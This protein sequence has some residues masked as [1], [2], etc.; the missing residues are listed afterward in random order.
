MSILETLSALM[1]GLPSARMG[2][3]LGLPLEKVESGIKQSLAVLLSAI[4]AKQDIA[5]ALEKLVQTAVELERSGGLKALVDG[6]PLA[7]GQD[8][9]PLI[10][11]VGEM[12]TELLNG[13]AEDVI[14]ALASTLSMPLD[15]AKRLLNQ[16]SL[17]LAGF[18]GEQLKRPGMNGPALAATLATER[19]GYAVWLPPSLASWYADK[20]AGPV[21]TKKCSRRWL[22]WVL[23]ALLVILA[24]LFGLKGCGDEKSADNP[25]ISSTSGPAAS[26]AVDSVKAA[27]GEFFKLLLPD[28]TEL[29]VPELGIENRL[30]KFIKDDAQQ[31]DPSIW[32]SF[33]RLTFE[34]NSNTLMPGSEEQLKNI[35]AIMKAFPKVHLKLGGYTDNTGTPEGNLTLSDARARSVM[36]EL[37]KLGVQADRLEAKGYG[38]EHPVASNDT[39]EGRAKNRRIDVNV[40]AK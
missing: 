38:Q 24:T 8:N 32:F 34:S 37:V 21:A 22:P 6:S 31:V 33:D 11:R 39:E 15:G 12:Q 1:K 20:S 4:A 2:A 3:H 10:S 16:A 29:N 7:T 40:T 27:L 23:L 28:G 17:L 9:A 30:V 36:D 19:P 14:K 13:R 5:G 26:G 35:A 18:V 25:A